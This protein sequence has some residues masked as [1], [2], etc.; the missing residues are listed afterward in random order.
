MFCLSIA[1]SLSRDN[2]EITMQHTRI[3]TYQCSNYVLIPKGSII[4]MSWPK[5][6]KNTNIEFLLDKIVKGY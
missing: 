1:F 4:A 2:N 5:P 6:R 3:R